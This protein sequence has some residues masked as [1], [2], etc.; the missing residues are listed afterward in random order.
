[1]TNHLKEQLKLSVK[2]FSNLHRRGAKPD[3]FV[4]STARSGSTFFN[5][6]FQTQKGVKV[7]DEPLNVRNPH[8][9]KALGITGWEGLLPNPARNQKLQDYFVR[10]R[11]NRVPFLNRI[12]LTRNHRWVTNR[13][14]FKILHGGEDMINWFKDTFQAKIVYL[15]RHPIAVTISREVF[16]KLPYF[17]ANAEYRSY[18]N[19]E[20][21]READH[22]LRSGT[23]FQQGILSWCLQNYPPLYASD[24]EDWLI[25]TYEEVVDR[26]EKVLP[27]IAVHLELDDPKRMIENIHKPS[28]VI[29]KSDEVT[30]KFFQERDENRSWL[31]RKWKERVTQQQEEQ[32][33]AI[34]QLFAMDIYRPGDFFPHQRFM[35]TPRE[36]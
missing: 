21:L 36:N 27:T 6:L 4:F 8:V 18:F 20:Q 30:R 5:E 28:R 32:A 16:P 10:I 12:P 34:V 13:L 3:I 7:I 29:T 14:V 24:H 19:K 9:T 33:F 26:P 11:D 35:L 15:V 31:I 2:R 1:M 22:I 23:H 25:A 17:L